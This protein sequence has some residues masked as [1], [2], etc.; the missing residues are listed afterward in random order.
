MRRARSSTTSD[1]AGP[2]PETVLVLHNRYRA[3]GGEDV[4]FDAE[5]ALLERHGHRVVRFEVDNQGIDETGGIASRIRLAAETVWSSRSARDIG[6]VVAAVS[7]DVVHVHNFFPLLSP[8]VFSAARRRGAA[9]V[10]TLHNYRLVC[11]VASFYRD[12]H[13]CED[14]LGR[15]VAWPGIVHKCYHRSRLATSTVAAMVAVNRAR[16]TWTHDVDVYIAA[17]E[18]LRAKVTQGILPANRVIASANFVD[19]DPAPASDPAGSFVFV[20]RLTEDKGVETLL[21][22]WELLP[23]NI[24]LRVLG[25]GPLAPAVRAAADR[26]PNVVAVGHLDHSLVREQLHTARGMVFSS[27]LYEGGLPLS[28]MEAFASGLP[29]IASRI[30][31]VQEIVEDDT[32]GLFYEPGDP[33]MLAARVRWLVENE[34]ARRRLADGALRTYRQRFT[35]ELGYQRLLHAYRMAIANRAVD[36]RQRSTATA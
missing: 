11:P 32:N 34:D 4:V 12:G 1:D 15:A 29:V 25:D 27:R 30:G 35:P 24:G 9:V 8:A 17:S 14:C 33:T 19:P 6:R 21:A 22:A 5:T 2:F 7:P 13:P 3:V 20:G 26:L 28:I 18:I 10:Q 16:G 36:T 23:P 31:A